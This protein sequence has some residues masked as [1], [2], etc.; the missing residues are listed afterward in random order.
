MRGRRLRLLASR[1]V[2]VVV[3]FGFGV[4]GA[5]ADTWV[6][7]RH[8][9]EYRPNG[10]AATEDGGRTWRLIF[11]YCGAISGFVHT[12]PRAGMVVCDEDTYF[13]TTD[14]GLHWVSPASIGPAR[15]FEGHGSYFYFSDAH[16][17]KRV[18]P[19]PPGV[20]EHRC[21]VEPQ[22]QRYGSICLHS[23][24]DLRTVEV[25]RFPG[26]AATVLANVPGGVLALV[27]RVSGGSTSVA[28][29]R[30]YVRRDG[31]PK[32]LSGLPNLRVQAQ[33]AATGYDVAVVWPKIDVYATNGRGQPLATWRSVDG[34]RTWRLFDTGS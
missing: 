3:L 29:L 6:G 22:K 31:H 14:N 30:V 12:G 16:G 11:D 32:T 10:L 17:L 25:E 24:K 5:G 20:A 34:A 28:P 13:W 9:W 15:D 23:T 1:G 27:E 8:G 21:R 19:W 7:D 26:A 4:G 2:C 33:A 18:Q